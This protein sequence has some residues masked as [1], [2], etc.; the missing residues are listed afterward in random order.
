MTTGDLVR[1]K[2]SACSTDH[3]EWIRSCARNKVPML[4]LFEYEKQEA[5]KLGERYF[6][7]SSIHSGKRCFE[8]LCEG[9]TFQAFEHELT[10]NGLD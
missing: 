1:F 10:K 2:M 5:R 3:T 4:I 7:K 9:D 6:G 8:M